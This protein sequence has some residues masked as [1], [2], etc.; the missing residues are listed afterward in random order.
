MQSK[1]IAYLHAYSDSTPGLTDFEIKVKLSYY[2]I[3]RCSKTV[4]ELAIDSNCTFENIRK[5]ILKAESRI[6]RNIEYGVPCTDH[7][8]ENIPQLMLSY[9]TEMAL[10]RAG[11]IT[12]R[13]LLAKNVY[14]V[15]AI[16]GLGKKSLDE[17]HNK[18][19]AFG[20][21]NNIDSNIYLRLGS[22]LFQKPIV[23]PILDTSKRLL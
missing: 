19:L 9:R 12:I 21:K 1:I 8:P 4:K 11:I 23:L 16:R 5:V 2:G 15:I 3:N 18:L 10:M 17:I 20:F 7:A 13:Q 22:T 6:L 14:E